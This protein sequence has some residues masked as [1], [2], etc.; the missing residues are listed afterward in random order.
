MPLIIDNE[1][2]VGRFRELVEHSD[3]GVLGFPDHRIFKGV[4][5]TMRIADCNSLAL[6]GRRIAFSH[7]YLKKGMPEGY[8]PDM[9]EELDEDPY[10]L[11]AVLVGG[12]D[13]H[14]ERCETV[15]GDNKIPIVG[16]YH[17]HFNTEEVSGNKN[18]AVGNK[19]FVVNSN[20]REAYVYSRPIGL[21]KLL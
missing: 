12:D 9:I 20:P 4:A 8:I 5:Q 2:I 21:K 13:E 7:Y 10:G 6:F 16:R 15:L 18:K 17:D 11:V 14:F 19:H 1:E 3:T